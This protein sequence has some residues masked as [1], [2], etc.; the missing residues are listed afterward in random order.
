MGWRIARQK[1]PRLSDKYSK[2]AL[3]SNTVASPSTK[4]GVFAFGLIALKAALCCS[5]LRV[6][7]GTTSQ[8]QPVSSSKCAILSGL[9]EGC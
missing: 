7:T 3:P 5:P 6:S 8:R 2:I 1:L 9:G 4:A